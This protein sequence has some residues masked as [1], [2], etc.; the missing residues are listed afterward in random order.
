ML[1]N[2]R[3]EIFEVYAKCPW[4]DLPLHRGPFGESGGLFAGYFE[5]IKRQV[6]TGSFF[7]DPEVI[8]S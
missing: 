5:E 7:L 6:Y 4:A 2:P 3:D 8:K 1:G